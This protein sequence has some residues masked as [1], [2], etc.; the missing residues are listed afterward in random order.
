MRDRIRLNVVLAVSAFWV[1]AVSAA[2]GNAPV[3][4]ADQTADARAIQT[5]FSQ[6]K[7]ALLESDGSRAADVLSARTIAFYDGIVQHAL[8]TSRAKVEE[9]DFISKLMVARIRLEF[10]R[11][12]I[13]RMTGREMLEIGVNNGWISKSS[14]ANIERLVEIKVDSSEAS[15][16]MPLA[17]GVPAFRFVKESEQWKLDLVAS[18]ALANA[19]MKQEITKSGLTEEEFIIRVLRMLS[20]KEVDEGIFSPPR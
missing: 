11:E 12:Q 17:P 7:A 6:Y 16:S 9:L 20:S 15:A 4:P 19:A 18:F 10:T 3:K 1:F 5:T 14:V 2:T 13:S 8:H